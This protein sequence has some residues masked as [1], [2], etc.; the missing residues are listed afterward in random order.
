MLFR[1]HFIDKN[2]KQKKEI[3][4]KEKDV[5][6][7]AQITTSKEATSGESLEKLSCAAVGKVCAVWESSKGCTLLHVSIFKFHL[8]A[9]NFYKI[10]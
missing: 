4:V 6:T 5:K 10:L 3:D 2:N 8:L 1:W 9:L 7:R